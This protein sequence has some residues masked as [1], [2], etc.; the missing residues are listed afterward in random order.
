MWKDISEMSG[1]CNEV[2]SMPGAGWECVDVAFRDGRQI[3]TG[4]RG[5]DERRKGGAGA[6]MYR[7]QVGI[8]AAQDHM[9]VRASE[10]ERVYAGE[11][12]TPL[13]Q[14]PIS[15]NDADV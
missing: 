12:G 3:V 13:R 14:T 15:V 7:M 10:T 1:G 6:S 4:M 8:G 9:G 11:V 5:D 2:P